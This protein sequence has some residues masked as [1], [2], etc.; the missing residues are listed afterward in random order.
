M[1]KILSRGQ[2]G[3]QMFQFAFAYTLANKLS[4]TFMIIKKDTKDQLF[5]FTLKDKNKENF[6]FFASRTLYNLKLILHSRL[7][8]LLEMI[9][10]IQS[11]KHYKKYIEDNW[12]NPVQLKS[13]FND[14]QIYHGYF[15]SET[16][17][18]AQKNQISNLF[19][20]KDKYTTLFKSKYN[21]IFETNM[22]L[23]IHMRYKDYLTVGEDKLGGTNLSL[24]IS[25]YINSLS[26]IENFES[27][28]IF[29][30]SDDVDLAKKNLPLTN[31]NFCQNEEIVD[32]QMIQHADVAIIANS[33]FA[34]WASWLNIKPHKKIY[35]PNYW[36]GFKV[37]KE[38]PCGIIPSEF[39]AVDFA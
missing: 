7:Y 32:F 39:H 25:Y 16:Y 10:S 23:V 28:K 3:N 21:K 33:T 5:Y 38:F 24:P 14:N 29:V 12:Q 20:I 27:F 30:L 37:K 4:T 22:T 8:T 34:W 9:L 18:K 31:A 26:I 13:E 1:I 17:F 6:H 11:S 35:V 2:L 15:Q 19:T 36:L